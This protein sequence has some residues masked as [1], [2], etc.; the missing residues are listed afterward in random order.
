MLHHMHCCSPCSLLAECLVYGMLQ[1]L[2]LV[3]FFFH[4]QI[5]Q[6]V[7]H[8]FPCWHASLKSFS[9]SH[10]LKPMLAGSQHTLLTFASLRQFITTLCAYN[11]PRGSLDTGINNRVTADQRSV[12]N[13]SIFSC[14][15]LTRLFGYW[16]QQPHH[17]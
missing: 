9:S 15:R 8:I 3:S 4:C 1:L 14:V 11:R 2:A 13:I 5:F 12:S 10:L 7:L 16:N 6:P 17:S